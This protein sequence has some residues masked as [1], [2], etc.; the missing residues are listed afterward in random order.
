MYY[1]Y[2]GNYHNNITPIILV[3]YLLQV[4]LIH[5]SSLVNQAVFFPDCA[6]ARAKGWAGSRDYVDRWSLDNYCKRVIVSSE[7]V[8]S[9]PRFQASPVPC[10]F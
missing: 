3:Y 10:V 6:C 2:K 9:D 8:A 7:E 1:A 4:V 5:D